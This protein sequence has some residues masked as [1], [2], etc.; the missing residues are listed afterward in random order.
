MDPCLLNQI[1][2]VN[3]S[4]SKSIHDWRVPGR[5]LIKRSA[6]ARNAKWANVREGIPGRPEP[7]PYRT[8]PPP[9]RIEPPGP[10]YSTRASAIQNTNEPL[11]YRTNFL[12]IGLCV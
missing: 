8:E 6:K 4:G 2:C 3:G 5:R 1:L 7:P 12:N 11:A 10:P 9:Y